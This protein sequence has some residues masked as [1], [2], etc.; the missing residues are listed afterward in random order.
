MTYIDKAKLLEWLQKEADDRETLRHLKANRLSYLRV[1]E[2][3]ESGTFDLLTD[4]TVEDASEYDAYN[5]KCEL[6]EAADVDVKEIDLEAVEILMKTA[7]FQDTRMGA[8]IQGLVESYRQLLTKLAL[9]DKAY[10]EELRLIE[11]LNKRLAEKEA[12][13]GSWKAISEAVQRENALLNEKLNQAV[14]AAKKIVA[15]KE[16]IRPDGEA[17]EY[18]GEYNECIKIAQTFLRFIK[19]GETHDT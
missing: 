14:E 5:L 11:K 4:V 9:I 6:E 8:R 19:E 17:W 12:E 18:I 3:I 2:H 16:N 7:L 1:K 15:T 10:D 13:D